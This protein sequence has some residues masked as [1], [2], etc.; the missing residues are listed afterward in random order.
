MFG[1]TWEQIKDKFLL[2]SG[3]IFPS[4]STGG[5]VSHK[6][7]EDELP[8][9]TGDFSDFALQDQGQGGPTCHGH[10]FS[11]DPH[12][13]WQGW[14]TSASGTKIDEIKFAFGGNQ[15]HNNMPPYISVYIFKR[16]S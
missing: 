7:S 2:A 3:D 16:I 12:G 8:I 15:Y 6:L 11:G 13:Q 4:G 5:E 14:G 9:I 1:G 10:F